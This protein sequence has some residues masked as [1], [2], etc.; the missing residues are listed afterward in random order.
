MAVPASFAESNAILDKPDDMTYDECEAISCLR[1]LTESGY[2]VVI[3]AWKL[4]REELAE[5][6][7]TGRLWLIV[8]GL[9]QPPMIVSGNKPRMVV[10]K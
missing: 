8:M 5:I 6:N 3:S 7:R 1:G 2:P 4:S 9:T 10:D